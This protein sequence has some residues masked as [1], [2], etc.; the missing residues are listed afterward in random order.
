M[1]LFLYILISPG[2][3]SHIII[4]FPLNLLQCV[5]K[6]D[7]AMITLLAMNGEWVEGLVTQM[8]NL[9]AGLHIDLLGDIKM[10]F[11]VC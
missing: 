9:L 3:A 1:F 6:A 2:Y 10:E 4:I 5:S 7:L 8:R 11:L